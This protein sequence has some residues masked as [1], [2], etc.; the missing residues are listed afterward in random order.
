LQKLRRSSSDCPLDAERNL[1]KQRFQSAATSYVLLRKL[2]IG[3][4]TT[5]VVARSSSGSS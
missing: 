3:V 2:P 5:E 1:L 4:T